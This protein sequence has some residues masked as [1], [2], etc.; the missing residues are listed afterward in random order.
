MSSVRKRHVNSSK[1]NTSS[2]SSPPQSR[3]QVQD[4]FELVLNGK[5]EQPVEKEDPRYEVVALSVITAL[6]FFTRFYKIWFPDEVVFD[7][8]HFGKF[9]SYYLQRTYFFD[10]HPPFAKLLIAGVG[11]LVGYDGT[12]KFDKIGDS[13][14]TNQAPYLAYRSL[15]AIQGSLTVPVLFLTMRQL[16][17]SIAAS[18]LASIIVLFDNAHVT[19]TRLIL[20]D[21]TLLLSVACS[22]YAYVRFRNEQLKKAFTTTWWKWLA[23]TGV[24]L[25]CVISTKYVGVFTFLTIGFAV[26]IDLWHLLD[27]ESG[28]TVREVSRHFVARF[29]GLIV[30]PFIIYLFWFYVHFSVLTK[31]GTGD[32]FMSSAFQ[33]T[34]GDSPLA[35]TAKQVNYYDTITLKHKETELLL[36]SHDAF[37][38]LRYEDGRVSSKGQQVTAFNGTDPNNEWVILPIHDFQDGS[39]QGHAVRIDDIVRLYHVGTDSYMLAHDV[40]SPLNP[41]NEEFTT[42]KGEVAQRRFNETLFK[43]LPA[44]RS[45]GRTPIK[46]KASVIR[47]LHK[48]TN[49]ALWTHDDVTLPDWAFNQYE[50][51]GN[52]DTTASSNSWIIDEIIGLD[53][54]RKFYVPKSVKTLPFLNKWWELQFLMFSHNNKLSSEHPFASDPSSWPLSLSGVSFWTNA[55][56]KLQIYFIGNLVGWWTEVL[57]MV[58][59]AGVYIGAKLAE[60][61]RIQIFTPDQINRLADIGFLYIGYLSHYVFFF[62]MTRQKF[63]HHYLPAHLLAALLTGAIAEFFLGRG[64]NLNIA[65][66]V[67]SVVLISF[68]IFYAPLTYGD[69]PLTPEQVKARQFFNI[70][71]SH[72]K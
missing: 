45:K 20:L 6:A 29:Y 38:P 51:N 13:Y 17:Y 36:H 42:V 63:L 70:R 28:L 2:S 34:L 47:I 57:V 44:D 68:F 61:R 8:V 31:S 9:A 37:Y 69:V 46:T 19:E 27:I 54:A 65:V 18:S 40:A 11:Y 71:L 12:F 66:L 21:A 32:A 3:S 7:E 26:I 60:Q 16:N 30:L 10:L 14:I 15:E 22:V 55:D 33:E 52:K 62:L 24:A 67:F 49:V 53:D 25:S 23:L 64:R 50:V 39:K 43:L 35:A 5:E 72:A 1:K 59:F 56:K 41:T 58:I 4:E 48:D